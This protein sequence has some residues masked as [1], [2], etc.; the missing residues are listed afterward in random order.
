VVVR[1][2]AERLAALGAGYGCLGFFVAF[3]G[4][5]CGSLVPVLLALGEGDFALDAA[6]AEIKLDRDEREALLRRQSF[7]FVDF[8]FMQQELTGAQ[9]LVIH[10]VAVRE[11]ANVGVEEETLAVLEETI[12]VLEVGLAFADGLDLRTTQGD[13]GFEAV[14]EEV[15]EAGGAVVGS[16]ALSGSDGI[17]ILG[18]GR[19]FGWRGDSRIGEGAGH[20][21]SGYWLKTSDSGS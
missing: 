1:A 19:G 11:R 3:A 5:F 4:A 8:S 9:R 16:V 6:V 13:A 20:E 14:G 18:L 10:G 2:T 21:G 15:V 12:G 17:A 7:K